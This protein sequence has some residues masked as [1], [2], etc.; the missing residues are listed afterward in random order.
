MRICIF[1]I[2]MLSG[3]LN[4]GNA[5]A[6]P[7][8]VA[9]PAG[10][11][12]SVQAIAPNPEKSFD[13]ARVDMLVDSIRQDVVVSKKID[14]APLLVIAARQGNAKA[15]N[16]LGWMFDNGIGTTK[17]EPAKAIKWFEFCARQSALA[18]YNAGVLY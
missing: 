18:S 16:L 15:C 14:R 11:I 13:V 5:I 6:E 1:S 12:A 10:L 7:N 4:C 8:A 17:K 2:A 9:G 3:V